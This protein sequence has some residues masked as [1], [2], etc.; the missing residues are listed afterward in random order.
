VK[1]HI[2]GDFDRD[3]I[4]LHNFQGG[5]CGITKVEDDTFNLCYLSLRAPLKKLGTVRNL[6]EKILLKNPFLR[7]I[8]NTAT[9]VFDK[10]VV[11]NEISFASKE[12]VSDHILMSGD[13]AGMI[14]PLCGNGIAMAIHSADILSGQV[15]LFLSGK[16]SRNELEHW[17]SHLWNRNFGSRIRAGRQ[18][19]TLF[20]S[21]A[22]S[23]LAVSL[24]K[25]SG[26][27]SK[28]IMRQTHGEVFDG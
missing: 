23:N 12:P 1:Y 16:Y 10:P 13:A 15:H 3:L 6:E 21:S 18:I 4:G 19:Q 27:L 24:I 22:A 28:W 20:G 25:R 11:I 2:K 14:T 7:H 26:L 17:Y 9:F 8:F 5:Y